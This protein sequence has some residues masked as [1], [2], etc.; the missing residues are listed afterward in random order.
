M[1]L[2][3]VLAGVFNGLLAPRLFTHAY[4]YPLVILLSFLALP[5]A[6]MTREWLMP[7]LVFLLL[8]VDYGL[9][10][11]GWIP[12]L[13]SYHVEAILALSIALIWPKSVRSLLLSIAI[14]FAF[15]FM[16]WFKPVQVL[17]Q[18][19]N[20]YGVK[21]V[22]AQAGAHVLLSQ[23]TIHGFQIPG[24]AKSTNGSRAYYGSVLPV[25][26]RLQALHQPLH[27]MVIG[28]GTGIMACQFRQH[29]KLTL[30]EIDQQVID[31]AS[32]PDLFTY[33]QDCSSE[34]SLVREDGRLAVAQSKDASYNLLVMDAF[35]SDAI[36]IHL[37]TIEAFTLYQQKITSDGV[38]LVNISNR[39]LRVLPVLTAAGRKLD[40]IVMHKKEAGDGRLGQ[41]P[42]EWALLTTNEKLAAS[43]L[44]NEGWRFVADGETR[45]WTNDYSNLVPLIKW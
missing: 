31:I 32:N 18:Q 1:S 2:G 17:S 7:T 19:R 21:Q 9:E 23:S 27:A 40:L 24:D 26:R 25:V 15:I 20:F 14:L 45:L 5:L 43:L 38:I 36:P 10:S 6:T 4:E 11:M 16:P 22:F 35:S 3:G 29:D 12:W 28:L 42:S 37:L 44:A 41:L 39:H 30:V 8:L 33:L 13:H 34:R